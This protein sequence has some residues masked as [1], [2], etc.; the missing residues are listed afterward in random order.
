MKISYKVP[1]IATTVIVIAFAAF[2]TIQYQLIKNNIYEQTENNI[3]ETSGLL[4][5][6]VSS[7]LNKRLDIMQGFSELVARSPGSTVENLRHLFSVP[8]F[9]ESASYYYG[10]LD[11]DGLTFS[12][13]DGRWTPPPN[14]DVRTRPW[15]AM[16]KRHRQAV[17]TAPYADAVDQRL[18]ITAVAQIYDGNHSI[19]VMGADIELK[20]V[21]D[22]VNTITFNDAGYAFL[23]NDE[24]KIITH[25]EANY[26]G[27]SIMDLFQG[28]VP[29]TLSSKLQ[30]SKINDTDVLTA[31][32]P[33]KQFSASEKGWLVGVVVD[34]KKILAPA[35][36][37]GKNAIIASV[38][39][40]ILSSIIFFL[41]MKGSLIT[42]VNQ[43][44]SQADEISRGRLKT[45]IVGTAR[46]DEIGDLANAIQRLQKSLSMAMDKIRQNR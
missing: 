25:P 31:F 29:T 9:Y 35:Y 14:I 6:D 27:K 37:L 39:A 1:L 15:Y 16:A 28:K 20:D 32:F 36:Q 45:K 42:P 2:S 7:W 38:I 5:A 40:A 24:G 3:N 10:A 21:S 8:K 19:G 43:L 13:L 30:Y 41:F 33:L 23:I 34:E 4:A 17:M 22:A 46:K 12:D 18:L 11:S 26:Y 44:T